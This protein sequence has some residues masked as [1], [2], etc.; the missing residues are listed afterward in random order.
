METTPTPRERRPLPDDLQEKI[1]DARI[2]V[3]ART[4]FFGNLLFEATVWED[5]TVPTAATDGKDIFFNADFLRDLE[6]E[7]LM[8]VL[9]HEVLHAALLHV[10]RRG[11]RHPRRWNIA[12]DMV[13]N[14]MLADQDFALPGGV[15]VPEEKSEWKGKSVEEIYELIEWEEVTITLDDRWLDLD[16]R[17]QERGE[18]GR[19]MDVEDRWRQAVRRARQ[20]Q[21]M[22]DHGE[23]PTALQRPVDRITSPQIDWRKALWRFLVKTPVDFKQFDRR[24]AHREL[25][26][27]TL[28]ADTLHL[29]LAIDTSGSI[30]GEHLETFLGEVTGILRSYPHIEAELYY[31][32]A[33]LYGPYELA[34]GSSPEDFPP[35][36]GGGGT[37][38][39][40]FFEAISEGQALATTPVAVYLT[41]G[42]G[43]FPPEEPSFPVL[44]VRTPG[45]LNEERFPFGRVVS[46]A[47]GP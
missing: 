15:R 31:A 30:R 11:E 21:R 16:E 13:I 14:E 36:E 1:S 39:V 26:V 6:F 10:S 40:P 22:S 45:G 28:Q 33:Q 4:P 9:A 3:R 18:A 5:P 47:S 38:F 2:A 25:Y 8:G 23:L 34:P 44:W 43:T 42:R 35:P 32:D 20:A 17:G 27:K 12:A 7:E 46:L 37:S 24:F 29:H 19:A 41:D